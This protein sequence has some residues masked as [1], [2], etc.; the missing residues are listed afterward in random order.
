MATCRK[1]SKALKCWVV[2]EFLAGGATHVSHDAAEEAVNPKTI[3]GS[4]YVPG[5]IGDGK[6]ILNLQVS[7]L[8]SDA[9]P[10]KPVIFAVSR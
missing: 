8:I 3:T 5:D 2:E 1:F 4:I 7:P 9:T 6:Y 10:S